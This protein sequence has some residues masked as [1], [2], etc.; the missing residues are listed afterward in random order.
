[1]N[2]MEFIKD[3]VSNIVAIISLI[4]AVFTFVFYFRDRR[5]EKFIVK[6]QYNKEILDWY[7]KTIETLVVL[8]CCELEQARSKYLSI[9][10]SQI[11]IGRF[12]FPNIDKGDNFGKTKP[13][14]YQGYRNLVLDFLVYSYGILKR[15]N[16]KDSIEQLEVFQREYTSLVFNIIKPSKNIEDIKKITDKYFMEEKIFED[17]LATKN[18]KELTEI[19]NRIN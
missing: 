2:F 17:Y 3:N 19:I 8:R 14:A 1:M 15:E 5:R 11:E 12:Y 16:Y 9:L 6:S 7:S 4:V 18:S 10:S 13:I